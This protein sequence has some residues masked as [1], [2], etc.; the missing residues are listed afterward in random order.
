MSIAPS[1][2]PQFRPPREFWH[3]TGPPLGE[4]EWAARGAGVV[5]PT[6]RR[7]PPDRAAD[8]QPFPQL[9]EHPRPARPHAADRRFGSQPIP[10]LSDATAKPQRLTE[11]L[12][13]DM[14]RVGLS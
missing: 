10:D 1:V 3:G 12:L 13:D 9:A 8:L 5:Q 6:A 2:E 14:H 11:S 4:A 7:H